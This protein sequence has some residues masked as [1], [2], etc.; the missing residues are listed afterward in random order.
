MRKQTPVFLTKREAEVLMQGFD[1]LFSVYPGGPACR[2]SAKA[3]WKA[4][5]KIDAAF[6]MEIFEK[7]A[8]DE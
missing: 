7:E 8:C 2:K 6:G 4:L 3:L 1:Q 5:Q